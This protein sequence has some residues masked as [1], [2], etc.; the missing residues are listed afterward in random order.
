[1]AA[2][3]DLYYIPL[4]HM[5]FQDLPEELHLEILSFLNAR[6]DLAKWRC[7]CVSTNRSL[8]TFRT[9]LRKRYTHE[10]RDGH[11]SLG[12]DHSSV[13]LFRWWLQM[14]HRDDES[15]MEAGLELFYSFKSTLGKPG[16]KTT[17]EKNAK[18]VVHL[19]RQYLG[20]EI[21]AA[22]F[23]RALEGNQSWPLDMWGYIPSN[24]EEALYLEQAAVQALESAGLSVSSSI[25]KDWALRHAER[26]GQLNPTAKANFVNGM[27][28]L[29]IVTAL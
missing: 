8:R 18:A 22:C 13:E 21:F 6:L 15:A 5:E 7:I 25:A 14:D 12:T 10:H 17:N 2:H 3:A 20:V 27:L 11:T 4:S 28:Y 19:L 1:M 23:R 26:L 16:G 29:D 24:S 9:T